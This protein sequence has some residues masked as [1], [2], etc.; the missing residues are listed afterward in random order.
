MK[1]SVIVVGKYFDLSLAYNDINMKNV[2][3]A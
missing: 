1:Q 2:S 3:I